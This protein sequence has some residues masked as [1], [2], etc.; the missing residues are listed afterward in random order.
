[1]ASEDVGLGE[2]LLGDS[3]KKK[4]MFDAIA[5]KQKQIDETKDT[6]IKGQLTDELNAMKGFYEREMFKQGATDAE[7]KLLAAKDVQDQYYDKDYLNLRKQQS[8]DIGT[9]QLAQSLKLAKQMQLKGAGN[10]NPY[11][12]ASSLEQTQ[13]VNQ[14]QLA[15]D[16]RGESL[17]AKS[18]ASTE[19]GR[20]QQYAAQITE[21]TRR[22]IMERMT[23]YLNQINMDEGTKA[24]LEQ[25]LAN[26]PDGLV[27]EL[28]AKGTQ[29]LVSGL[30]NRISGKNPN[31]KMVKGAAAGASAGGVWGGILGA[32]GGLVSE[33]G[34]SDV[35]APQQQQQ[36][37]F[38]SSPQQEQTAWDKGTKDF[39]GY[40]S[41]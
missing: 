17:R 14:N 30:L 23:N 10:Y 32:I 33:D 35:N 5:E 21:E 12:I 20:K 40:G 34:G 19:L 36:Q 39:G 2:I 22:S 26:L 6:I 1:M 29:A 25:E 15:G 37:S 16:L 27:N 28:G 9:Q 7:G 18:E 31:D 13:R 3:A 24:E 41:R 11:Q 8:Q 4:R 38:Y